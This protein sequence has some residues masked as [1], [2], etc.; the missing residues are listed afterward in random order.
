MCQA[1]HLHLSGG[2]DNDTNDDEHN[3]DDNNND[4]G[5]DQLMRLTMIMLVQGAVMPGTFI[6]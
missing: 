3:D 5:E 4:Y 1:R 2:D 6:C